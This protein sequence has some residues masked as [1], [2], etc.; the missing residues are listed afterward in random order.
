M[1][2]IQCTP[3][4]CCFVDEIEMSESEARK[5]A[6]ANWNSPL[7]SAYVL[8]ANELR[9]VSMRH[10]NKC[11]S[12]REREPQRDAAR[13]V[14]AASRLRD[15]QPHQQPTRGPLIPQRGRFSHTAPIQ[16]PKSSLDGVHP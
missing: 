9:R 6:S 8:V 16:Q 11:A 12:C 2:K 4:P 13:A 7:A 10:L 14:Q 1:S 5:K 3:P 15:S